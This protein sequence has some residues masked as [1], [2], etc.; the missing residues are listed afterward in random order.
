MPAV[1]GRVRMA[2]QVRSRAGL[3]LPVEI[4]YDDYTPDIL[5]NQLLRTAVGASADCIFGTRRHMPR[6]PTPPATRRGQQHAV[7][8]YVTAGRVAAAARRAVLRCRHLR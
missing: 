6:A 1:W 3:P 4:A 8:G 2:S 5:E 7:L